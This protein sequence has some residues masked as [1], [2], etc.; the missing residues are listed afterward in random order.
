MEIFAFILIGGIWAAFLLPSLM[1]GRRKAPMTSTRSFARSQDLLASVSR[2]NAYEVMHRKQAGL[3]RRRILAA[4]GAG[5]ALSLIIAIF[6]ASTLWLG[7][8]I[9]FDVAVAGYVTLLL[10]SQQTTSTQAQVV[11][12]RVVEEPEHA[13][14]TVRV[15]AG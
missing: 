9:F 1:D 14:A 12:L 2:S 11:P 7:V 8:S 15:V 6:Q 10:H 13:S 5:A 3:R 4:L